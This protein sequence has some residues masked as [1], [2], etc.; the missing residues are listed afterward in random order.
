VII[1]VVNFCE[2]EVSVDIKNKKAYAEDLSEFSRFHGWGVV[3]EDKKLYT[4]T[5]DVTTNYLEVA[6]VK[7]MQH[8]GIEVEDII[9]SPLDRKFEVVD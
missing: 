7:A 6:M 1:R 4:N 2:I 9:P 3:G 5:D 8:L